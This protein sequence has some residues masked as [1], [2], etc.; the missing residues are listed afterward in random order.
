MNIRESNK[1][2]DTLSLLKYPANNSRRERALLS[3][4]NGVISTTE[5]TTSPTQSG[6]HYCLSSESKLRQ[7][8]RECT[9][10]GKRLNA[11]A[12]FSAVSTRYQN[13]V[14]TI[15]P[16][17]PPEFLL[18][19]PLP[20]PSQITTSSTQSRHRLRHLKLRSIIVPLARRLRRHRI[21][22][23]PNVADG[24]RAAT[25]KTIKRKHDTGRDGEAHDDNDRLGDTLAQQS[26][27]LVPDS[28]LAGS[29]CAVGS[30]EGVSVGSCCVALDG[31]VDGQG[32]GRVGR[33]GS[34]LTRGRYVDQLEVF[35]LFTLTVGRRVDDVRFL[36]HFGFL[37]LCSV[38]F[39][40][41]LC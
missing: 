1:C 9:N 16:L 18:Q 8:H 23:I 39:L 14:N 17:S 2:T 26:V 37:E 30:C 20:S 38:G 4:W 10:T 15:S 7:I 5:T 36:C 19:H 33:G 40:L 34:G 3:T 12:T 6:Y 11:Q 22:G 31:L 24:I 29:D 41:L 35:S 25:D 21:S 28:V 13:H 32:V 27:E